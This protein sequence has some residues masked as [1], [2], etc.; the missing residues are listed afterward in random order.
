MVQEAASGSI[1]RFEDLGRVFL[2]QFMTS[3]TQKK[4]PSYLLTLKQ[5]SSE[6]LK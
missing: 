1:D 3:R 5:R 2:T 6:T 4:P